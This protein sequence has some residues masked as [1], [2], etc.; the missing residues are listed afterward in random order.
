[1]AAPVAAA[2]TAARVAGLGSRRW[3]GMGM[4]GMGM[5]IVHEFMC[6]YC[7]GVC[8]VRCVVNVKMRWGRVR[9]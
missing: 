2:R 7:V 5:V 8:L 9:R 1:M 4:I 6:W 3:G